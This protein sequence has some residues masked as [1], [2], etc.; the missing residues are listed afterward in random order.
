MRAVRKVAIG[1]KAVDVME[2]QS[3]RMDR[4]ERGGYLSR[5]GSDRPFGYKKE[6]TQPQ[7]NR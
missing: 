1:V 7:Y 6:N 4:E 3:E 5:P 2:R